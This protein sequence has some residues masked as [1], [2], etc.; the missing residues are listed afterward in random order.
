VDRSVYE[1]ERSALRL[2]FALLGAMIGRCCSVVFASW[3]GER[4]V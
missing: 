4:P 3:Y 1:K 2:H